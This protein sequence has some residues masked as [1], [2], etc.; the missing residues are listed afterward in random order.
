MQ[1]FEFFRKKID[2]LLK[3]LFPGQ[4]HYNL[5]FLIS[6]I[7]IA[8]LSWVLVE[9]AIEIAEILNIPAAIIALTILAMGTSIPDL[10]SS[11]IAARKGFGGMAISNAIGSNVF[12]IL[13]G[14]GLPWAIMILIQPGRS[15]SVSTENL[16]S[17][18]ILLFATVIV[19][20][21]LLFFQKWKIGKYGGYFLV[22]L[23]IAY[24]VWAILQAV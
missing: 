9:S 23:Y 5:V 18:V 7:W 12:D 20:F 16:M 13:I 17:S 19:I 15:L 22:S 11:V 1:T 2:D 6:I 21:F 4:K 24:L 10:M 8:A 3:F 14:L